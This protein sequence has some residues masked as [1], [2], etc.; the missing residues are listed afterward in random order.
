MEPGFLE[1]FI[2]RWENYFPGVDLP[3]CF[4]YTDSAAPEDVAATEHPD[5]C[6]IGNI[7]RVR[8]GR[9]YVY[10]AKSPGCPGGK[11]YSGFTRKLRPKFEYFLSCGIPGELE[12]E[13]YKKSPELVTE[14][15][16]R[17]PP[18]D[19]TG[20]YLVFKRLDRLAPGD[21]PLAAIFFAAPDALSGLF[22]LANYDRVDANGVIAPMGSGC[23]SILYHPLVEA[24]SNDPRCVLGMFDVSA[25]PS[26]PGNTLTFT[27]PWKKFEAMAR[28]MDES[29]LI[30]GSW[31]LVRKRL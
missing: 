25:R 5:R 14:L 15:L 19:A 21:E 22:T 26:V 9:P 29:F 1:Y 8:E 10:D 20:K 31:D 17:Y 18:R 16:E 6:I 12:G 30:T 3:V 23:S 2:P 28:D 4:F 7:V 27:V 11:R 24:D 13:R